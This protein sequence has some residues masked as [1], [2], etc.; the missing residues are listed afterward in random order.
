VALVLSGCAVPHRI[1]VRGRELYSTMAMRHRQGQ[2]PVMGTHWRGDRVVGHP[3]VVVRDGQWLGVDG[4]R[5]SLRELEDGC[6]LPGGLA[7]PTP[8][9][10]DLATYS[11]T[12][13]EIKTY[14]TRALHVPTQ[15]VA[16]AVLVAIGGMI[17]CA[18][19]CPDDSLV[20]DISAGVT[21]TLGAAI[22]A[23]FVWAIVD[24]LFVHGLGSPGCRD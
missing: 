8:G 21:V 2:S 16:P 15:V 5:M 24:C 17:G 4:G 14:Q 18:L 11:N 7:T 1:T 10:C 3:Q 9:R 23:V 22:G 12:E 6:P 20:Q 19:Q 13:F